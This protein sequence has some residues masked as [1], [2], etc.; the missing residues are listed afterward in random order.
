MIWKEKSSYTYIYN[1]CIYISY[2]NRIDF[3][4]SIHNIYI[5]IYTHSPPA[6]GPNLI[7]DSLHQPRNCKPDLFC[8]DETGVPRHHCGV[9]EG[10]MGEQLGAPLK[11]LEHQGTM[12]L[13]GIRVPIYAEIG[14][15]RNRGG[16]SNLTTV[17][18]Y[19]GVQEGSSQTWQWQ[20]IFF[21]FIE[22]QKY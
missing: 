20:Y 2:I 6:N 1:I 4:P 7:R 19:W 13:R 8:V 10:I 12:V 14:I 17:I 15:N 18:L 11:P 3:Y 22:Q 5:S 9:A 21:L 16:L